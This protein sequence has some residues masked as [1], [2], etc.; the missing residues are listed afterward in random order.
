[1]EGGAWVL[2]EL[3]KGGSKWNLGAGKVNKGQIKWSP[4]EVMMKILGTSLRAKEGTNVPKR[5][6]SN[7]SC[8]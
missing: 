2:R 4:S 3:H 5:E 1:M 7:Q 8:I 6:W